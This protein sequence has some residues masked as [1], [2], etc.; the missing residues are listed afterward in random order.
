MIGSAEA[1]AVVG[2]IENGAS[3]GSA[4][5]DVSGQ[6]QLTLGTLSEGPHTLSASAVDRAGN[7]STPSGSLTVTIDTTPPAAPSAPALAPTSDTGLSNGD[8]LTRIAAPTFTGSAEAGS[9]ID[10]LVGGS[11]VGT[12]TASGA[13]L[14]TITSSTLGEGAQTVL[15]RARDAAGNTR[16]GGDV[17]VTIDVTG[18][19]APTGIGL[20]A[21]TDS[22][23]QG[24]AVTNAAAPT[25]TGSAEAGS[26]VRLYEGAAALATTIANG[27][28]VWE[29][30]AGGLGEGRHTLTVQA[31]DAAGNTGS[32]SAGFVVT[33][34]RSVAAPTGL[35]LTAGSDTGDAGDGLT[36]LTAPAIS[37]IA[38]AA[39]LIRL[40][41]G[42]TLLGTGTADGQGAWTV[43]SSALV[44]GS[45]SLTAVAVDAAGNTSAA[46]APLAITLDLVAP[47][48]P[49]GLALAGGSDSGTAGDGVTNRTAPVITGSAEV[50]S[51]IALYDGNA[52]IGTGTADAVSGIWSVQAASALIEG[53]HTL[54][55]IAGDRAGNAGAASAGF[56]VTIDTTAPAIGTPI[57]DADGVAPTV[58]GT[59]EAGS[60]VTLYD[61][62]SNGAVL[63]T[64]TAGSA[65]AWSIKTPD[66]APATYTLAAQ[67]T[68]AAGNVGT[69]QLTLTLAG[70][71]GTPGGL[72]LA[73]GSDSADPNDR[74]TRVAAPTVTGTAGAGVVVTL[75]DNGT[76]N[77]VG[78]TTAGTAGAWAITATALGDGTHVLRAMGQ[79][80]TAALGLSTPL[81]ITIDTTAPEAGGLALEAASDTGA[82]STD[83]LTRITNPVVTG[84]AEAGSL[85]TLYD[86]DRT[87]VVGRATSA[88]SG[89]WSATTTLG[90]GVHT[91]AAQAVDV[92]G[93]TGSVGAGFVLTI[94]TAAAAPAILALADDLG[95]GGSH[96]TR[97]VAP[98]VTGTAEAGGSV[99]LYADGRLVGTGNA[100]PASGAWTVGAAALGDGTHTLTA[101][102]VDRA[103]NTS[104]ASA[105]FVLSIDSTAP[106]APGTPA[107]SAD[108]GTPGDGVTRERIQ[109]ITGTAE[110]GSLV[111]LY[112]NGTALAGVTADAT[113]GAWSI[114]NVTLAAGL[115]T[116][117]A[118]AADAAGNTGASSAALAL[119]IDLVSDI[120]S[121]LALSAASDTGLSASDRVTRASA[122]I[123]TGS[124]EAASN[125]TLYDG[126]TANPVGT[127]E[128]DGTGAWSLTLLG[129]VE[130]G[131]TFTATAI[132]PAGNTSAA[133]AALT[134]TVD[135]TI[136]APL[137]PALDAGSDTGASATD[138]VTR[139]LAPTLTGTVEAGAQVW[140]Y[141]GNALIGATTADPTGIW[142]I[143][144]GLAEGTHILST[145]VFDAAG[146]SAA[147]SGSLTVT[148]DATAPGIPSTPVLAAISDTGASSSD[149]VTR[150]TTPILSGL[151]EPGSTV[152]LL[153][154][155]S[156]VGTVVADTFGAWTL[157]TGSLADGTHTLTARSVDLAG[158]RPRPRPP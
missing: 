12:G 30:A 49:S 134:V 4:T 24:D 6:W 100:D 69:A 52:L 7:T 59:A 130:G 64:A 55:A 141:E 44:D 96:L 21:A 128:A 68:D 102:V 132:D 111:T 10:L 135:R 32:A 61:S 146:N 79:D 80:G 101:Q 117:T 148:I 140:L 97:Q 77:A 76:T 121:G 42:Q 90:A 72:A 122:L 98:T 138:H 56:T 29:I 142:R 120:P 27:Q 53:P 157:A 81:T 74:I 137:A 103:G 1:F 105:G 5:A 36:R 43:T 57:A 91:L 86:S 114:A 144:Q 84:T 31:E 39:G 13:G 151:A 83:R 104:V 158:N 89:A 63:G 40:Y 71:Q 115:H 150:A 23:I 78:T 34:D 152:L 19:L 9:V 11:T 58:S 95:T 17:T 25:L 15:A 125:V 62:P 73:S 88:A 106:G 118:R 66:L 123:L 145:R 136:A 50:G 47:A 14:W 143:S 35:A 45:H 93:N 38:E 112:D 155:A 2:L 67:A 127:V 26:T 147:S 110:A 113:S 119:T 18:P 153:E 8:R 60:V 108:T 54:T 85:I 3:L 65:G 46:S 154:G 129:A 139:L 48:A 99:A 20:T 16:D 156:L 131:H 70:R 22:G 92:A 82:S 28:G 107:F 87:T 41:E 116:L 51:A 133:S 94:D 124:A 149:G 37:G 109:T 75:Y 126:G 33:I